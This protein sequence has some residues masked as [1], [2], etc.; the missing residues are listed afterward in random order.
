MHVLHTNTHTQQT[1]IQRYTHAE[2]GW[3][4]DDDGQ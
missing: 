3:E 2:G 4:G 1:K